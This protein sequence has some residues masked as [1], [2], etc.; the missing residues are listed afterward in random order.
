MTVLILAGGDILERLPFIRTRF[1]TPALLP[2]HTR[3]LATHVINAYQDIE[4]DIHLFIDEEFEQIVSQE[5]DAKHHGFSLHAISP[6]SSVIDTLKI[7]CELT[8]GDDIIVNLVTTVPTVVPEKD[9]IQVA[10]M[11]RRGDWAAISNSVD[12]VKFHSKGSP[13]PENS[14]AFTG[15]FRTNRERLVQAASKAGDSKDLLSVV[16]HLGEINAD[17]LHLTSWFDFGHEANY[18]RSIASLI[19]SRSFNAIKV[20]STR[21]TIKKSSEDTAKLSREANYLTSLPEHLKI[22]FPRL[23]SRRDEADCGTESYEMEYYGYPNLAEYL[24]YWELSEETWWRC[25]DSLDGIMTMFSEHPTSIDSQT[26]QDFLLGKT[27]SRIDA[28]ISNCPVDN[29]RKGLEKGNLRL[30][31]KSLPSLDQVRE[32]LSRAFDSSYDGDAFCIYHGDLC[33]NNILFDHN[34]GLI[35]MI[36]PRGSF[37]DNFPGIYG[38]RRYDLAKIQHSSTGG[39]DY[40]VNGLY[41]LDGLKSDWQLSIT[42]RPADA[43]LS[44]MTKWLVRRH[45][46]SPEIIDL[47]TASLFLSMCP[48][49]ADDP[50][51]QMALFL[52]GME[53][54]SQL[55]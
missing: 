2:V 1:S 12:G 16:E 50:R 37:G 4:A 29:F 54:T 48:L 35:R 30:N 3:H 32:T 51:R 20:D 42:S 52:R 5:L 41:R 34:S 19:S 44:E 27:L 9:E 40:I 21:G 18:H 11:P 13:Q 14:M 10:S 46:S 53:L 15:V 8:T 55:Q 45:C 17:S 22:L 47:F 23:L 33:F 28:Y 25:F 39:Y 31:G 36:D 26:F 49:H 7:A 43:W 38:D 24:L 6:T